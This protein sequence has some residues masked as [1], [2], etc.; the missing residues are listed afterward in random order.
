MEETLNQVCDL[1]GKEYEGLASEADQDSLC[2]V[3]KNMMSEGEVGGDQIIIRNIIDK[4]EDLIDDS[5]PL[6]PEEEDLDPF[7]E[8]DDAFVPYVIEVSA[9][10]LNIRRGPGRTFEVVGLV[11]EGK[12]F[13]VYNEVAG[14]GIISLA[15][16]STPKWV[17][18]DYCKKR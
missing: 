6:T 3:C 14:Y 4:P 10:K 1:C 13:T 8:P 18:L 12:T 5:L 17:D 2:P 11:S 9:K 16:E 15:Q 7:K